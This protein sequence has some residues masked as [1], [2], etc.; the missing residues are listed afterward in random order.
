MTQQR[1]RETLPIYSGRPHLWLRPRQPLVCPNLIDGYP[2]KLRTNHIVIREGEDDAFT[3]QFRRDKDGLECGAVIYV[4]PFPGGFR[5]MARVLYSEI[6]NLRG[7]EIP[8]ILEYLSTTN[9]FASDQAPPR[10]A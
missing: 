7:K 3:C 1:A 4:L 8:E 9:P 2:H 6:E 5:Y 10:S